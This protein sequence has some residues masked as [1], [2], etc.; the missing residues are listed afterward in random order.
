MSAEY[1][2]RAVV[3]FLMGKYA[4]PM[5]ATILHSIAILMTCSR[6][7]IRIR[8]R[9]LWWEDAWAALASCLDVICAASRWALTSLDGMFH[10]T[11]FSCLSNSIFLA[12]R[13]CIVFSVIRITPTAAPRRTIAYG[14]TAL[15]FLLWVLVFASKAYAC[16]SDTSW[17]DTTTVQCPIGAP[18]AII[19]LTADLVA[20]VVLVAIPIRT[21]CCA[22]LARRERILV[23][24]ICSMSLVSF[25]GSIVHADFLI[26]VP[27]F[28]AS[29]TADIEGSLSLMA[30]NLLA[31]VTYLHRCSR[32]G[33]DIESARNPAQTIEAT[34]S[35]EMTSSRT[36][37]ETLT[38]VDLDTDL[39]TVLMDQSADR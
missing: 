12:S 29:M 37:L 14:A 11:R 4:R 19:E 36:T 9:R 15:F 13:M 26:P 35:I 5:F 32:H 21:L 33:E 39:S 2:S 38:T 27:I 24:A 28:V 20:D 3:Q 6:L 10:L 17:Y 22:T 31:L 8:L 34:E 16:G 1:P 23:F 7:W 18:V 30:C 25:Y